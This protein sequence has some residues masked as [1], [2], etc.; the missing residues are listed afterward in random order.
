M[1]LP[2]GH[3]ARV[4][5]RIDDPGPVAQKSIKDKVENR[6]GPFNGPE[7]KDRDSGEYIFGSVVRDI[8]IVV[9][10]KCIRVF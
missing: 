2:R 3:G 10:S 8:A 9:S 6:K 4:G 1:V 5:W 7:G